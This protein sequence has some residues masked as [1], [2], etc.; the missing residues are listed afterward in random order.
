METKNLSI[1]LQCEL[2]S[3]SRATHY[4]QKAPKTV[5]QEDDELLKIIDEEYTKT[6][7]YGSRR[8]Q[9]LLKKRG[10]RINRK[11]VQRLMGIVGIRG[12]IVDP[13]FKTAV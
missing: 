11:R 3:V 7:F 2:A 4:T 10:Y 9:T 8:M 6:P 13:I 1:R 12:V 5:D